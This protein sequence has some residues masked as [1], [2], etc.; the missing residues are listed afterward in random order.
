VI[1]TI[2]LLL[3][4]LLPTDGGNFSLPIRG[5]FLGDLRV[6][7][8]GN[9]KPPRIALAMAGSEYLHHILSPEQL[10]LYRVV[11]RDAHRFPE[12]G[13]RYREQVIENRT[14]VFAQ[15]LNRWIG[16]EKWKV[17][18]G[19][20]AAEVFSALLRAGLFEEALFGLHRFDEAEI[21]AHARMAAG[22][23]LLLLKAGVL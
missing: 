8:R 22:N 3:K 2:P 23:M 6:S 7:A 17:K 12:L 14:V 15:Y 19:R 9:S 10:A 5:A 20:R 13:R 21:T 18:D 4:K 1:P 16:V 11:T